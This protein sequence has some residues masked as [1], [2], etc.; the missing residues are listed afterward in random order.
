MTHFVKVYN[1]AMAMVFIP[2]SAPSSSSGGTSSPRSNIIS[3]AVCF[4]FAL[5]L[6]I[7]AARLLRDYPGTPDRAATF[8][9]YLPATIASMIGG[10][11]LIAGLNGY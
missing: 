9:A 5:A 1:A 3:G 11:L 4:C 7:V 2:H 10:L 8:L 6:C